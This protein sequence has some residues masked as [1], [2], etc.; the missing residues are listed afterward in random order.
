MKTKTIYVANDGTT[1]DTEKDCIEYEEKLTNKYVVYYKDRETNLI[2]REFYNEP[3]VKRS[4]ANCL[5]D[6]Y[7]DNLVGDFK[8]VHRGKTVVF[9]SEELKEFV[10]AHYKINGEKLNEIFQLAV[11]RDVKIPGY[12][13]H[14]DYY[15]ADDIIPN[16]TWKEA[17]EIKEEIT[18]PN[19]KTVIARTLSKKELKTIPENERGTNDCWYWTSTPNDDDSAWYVYGSRGFDDYNGFNYSDD[20]GGAR[21]GFKNPFAN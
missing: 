1:F 8:I 17:C 16:K 12:T 15:L 20:D 14:G 10:P 2:K 6:C 13:L 19:G 4:I 11:A 18:L 21:L 5:R 3:L 9:N 7:E